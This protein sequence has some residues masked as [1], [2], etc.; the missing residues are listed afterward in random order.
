MH[1]VKRLYK[2]GLGSTALGRRG[3]GGLAGQCCDEWRGGVTRRVG[4]CGWVGP[5]AALCLVYAVPCKVG[6]FMMKR[7]VS[8]LR[9]VHTHTC[10]RPLISVIDPPATGHRTRH[11]PVWQPADAIHLGLSYR[12]SGTVTTARQRLMEVTHG[13]T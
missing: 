12:P 4:T 13:E 6:V 10:H 8:L 2:R 11:A 3:R 9:P 1:C 7:V 5:L